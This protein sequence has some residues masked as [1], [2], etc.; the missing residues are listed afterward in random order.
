M[1][2]FGC[3]VSFRRARMA[4]VFVLACFCAGLFA[5]LPVYAAAP[6]ATPQKKRNP[7]ARKAARADQWDFHAP[8][9]RFQN[10]RWLE[11]LHVPFQETS[12]APAERYLRN[13][14]AFAGQYLP[15]AYL[16]DLN[17]PHPS[18]DKQ[19][20]L[21]GGASVY[22]EITK[23]RTG[24]RMYHDEDYS[25]AASVLKEE[26]RAGVYAGFHPDEA[27]ELKIGP[28]YHLG[29]SVA[30]PDQ[31]GQAKDNAGE[32]GMGMKLKIGF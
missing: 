13:N 12:F 9:R 16:H 2:R 14:G 11:S 21:G 27:V 29:S 1:S 20:M 6:V 32:W 3:A 18:E 4:A 7:P 5:E 31:T 10:S 8:D 25:G 24:W 30:R 26:R 19:F 23:E 22:G 15:P 17:T 28:E